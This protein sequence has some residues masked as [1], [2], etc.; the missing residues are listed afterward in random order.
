MSERFTARDLAWPMALENAFRRQRSSPIVWGERRSAICRARNFSQARSLALEV[1]PR[2][3]EQSRFIL[4]R[5]PDHAKDML[6]LNRQFRKLNGTVSLS[7][8]Y[9]LLRLLFRFKKS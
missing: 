8:E 6:F 7:L 2:F 1:P 3:Q 9:E 5:L 4:L